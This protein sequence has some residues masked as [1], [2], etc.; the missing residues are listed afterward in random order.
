VEDEVAAGLFYFPLSLFEA[1][2]QVYRNFGQS[3]ADV[4]GE[5]VLRLPSFLRFGSW[6]GG[7]RDGNPYVTPEMT[8]L[9]VRMQ[10]ATILTE[11]RRRLDRLLGE[12]SHSYGLCQPSAEFLQSLDSD[13]E[14]LGDTAALAKPFYEPRAVKYRKAVG[15]KFFALLLF[16]SCFKRLRRLEIR[17]SPASP[18]CIDPVAACLGAVRLH[19]LSVLSLVPAPEPAC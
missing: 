8:A 7:D 12:L 1:T 16:L 19:L 6:I 17:S 2:C 18:P 9:A 15:Y 3:L 11:Y 10:A 5:G 4:Y 13:R 14:L